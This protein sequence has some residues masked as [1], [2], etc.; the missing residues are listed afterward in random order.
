VPGDNFSVSLLGGGEFLFLGSQRCLELGTVGVVG[1]AEGFLTGGEILLELGQFLLHFLR[2]GPVGF[3]GKLRE[4]GFV[5]RL[6][7]S[8]FRLRLVTGGED[9]LEGLRGFPL[10]GG[11]GLQFLIVVR[12]RWLTSLLRLHLLAEVGNTIL[13]HLHLHT[14]FGRGFFCLLRNVDDGLIALDLGQLGVEPI[15]GAL[16]L[17][18][19]RRGQDFGGDGDLCLDTHVSSWSFSSSGVAPYVD[20]GTDCGSSRGVASR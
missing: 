17:I 11:V 10:H 8:G 9:G 6:D 1:L 20:S 19:Q 2:D 12:G 5:F 18:G 3:R 13:V 16:G 15:A 14:F 4:L 7:A